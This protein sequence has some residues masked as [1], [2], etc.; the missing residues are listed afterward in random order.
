MC[1]IDLHSF[2]ERIT[3]LCTHIHTNTH[4]P[5]SHVYSIFCMPNSWNVTDRITSKHKMMWHI[6]IFASV[7]HDALYPVYL[8]NVKSKRSVICFIL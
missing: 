3:G 4:T 7:F 5:S 2:N 1:F 6:Q 8:I